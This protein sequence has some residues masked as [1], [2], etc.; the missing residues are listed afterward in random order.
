LSYS[1][2]YL[3]NGL[4]VN[5]NV[6]YRMLISK[7]SDVARVLDD[8]QLRPLPEKVPLT[9]SDPVPPP[10]EPSWNLT[11][12][13]VD[14]VKSELGVTGTGILIGQADSGVDGRHTE[15]ASSYRGFNGTDDYNWLDP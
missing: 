13:G 4:E 10:S 14:K 15:L 7:R 6:Y 1:S 5:T 2:Y 3:V 11:M 8:P 12:I 9:N